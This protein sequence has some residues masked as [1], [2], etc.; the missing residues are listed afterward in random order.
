MEVLDENTDY[1]NAHDPATSPLNGSAL[2]DQAIRSVVRPIG[3][4]KHSLLRALYSY[5]RNI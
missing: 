4:Q 1:S 3:D 5:M 2:D